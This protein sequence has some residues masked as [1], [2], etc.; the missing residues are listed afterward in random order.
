MAVTVR[1]QRHGS[2]NRPFFHIVAADRRASA[3]TKFIEKIGYYDPKT[4]PSTIEV[5][6]DRLQHYYGQGAIL[7]NMVSKFVKI[8]KLSLERAKTNVPSKKTSKAKA[9]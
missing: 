6:V 5:K 2:L 8:K 1:L 7:S 3:K 9:K 4:N